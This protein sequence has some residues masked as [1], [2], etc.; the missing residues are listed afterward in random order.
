M[1]EG[2]SEVAEGSGEH[3]R[4]GAY[5]SSL[6]RVAGVLAKTKAESSEIRSLAIA[7]GMTTLSIITCF[8]SE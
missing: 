5:D 2:V 1:S 8:Q 6:E 7:A 4:Y 3:D